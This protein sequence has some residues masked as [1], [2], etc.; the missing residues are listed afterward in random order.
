[1]QSVI[2][3]NRAEPRRGAQSRR[4]GGAFIRVGR[5]GRE[6]NYPGL[7]KTPREHAEKGPAS[8][9]RRPISSSEGTADPTNSK[10]K[11]HKAPPRRPRGDGGGGGRGTGRL[12][13]ASFTGRPQSPRDRE[14]FIADP[15]IWKQSQGEPGRAGLTETGP[16]ACRGRT[17]G[18][19][20]V[21]HFALFLPQ[22]KHV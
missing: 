7:D 6:A 21:F 5:G 10:N 13:A 22:M 16:P 4:D 12:R 19:C 15:P 18:F 3:G 1:M 2:C 14:V 8:L 9:G 11:A 20:F 17:G